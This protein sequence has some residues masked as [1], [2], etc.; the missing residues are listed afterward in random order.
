MKT[1]ITL[2]SFLISIFAINFTAHA[3][4][5]TAILDGGAWSSAGTWDT[6]S[7]PSCG[8]T[9][10]IPVGIDVKVTTNVVLD[11]PLDPTCGLVRINVAGA[12]RFSAGKKI[13]LAA[14]ACVNVEMGGQIS[15]SSKGGGASEAIE[16]D[17]VK[18]WQASD[19][20]Y[21]GPGTM[22]CG[23]V[24]P[25]VML[26]FNALIQNDQVSISWAVASETDLAYYQVSKSEDGIHWEA[27]SKITPSGSLHGSDISYT[28]YD[29]FDPSIAISYYKLSSFDMN[30]QE[31]R[32]G[33]RSVT[34]DEMDEE[35]NIQIFPNPV[36]GAQANIRFDLENERTVSVVI[37]NQMGQEIQKFDLDV[38]KDGSTFVFE[39]SDVHAGTYF[40]NIVGTSKSV[41]SKLVVL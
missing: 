29:V 36:S 37:Y 27:I 1:A 15:P 35:T 14:G 13:R 34:K 25:V 19:G 41:K 5:V 20:V 30:G 39:T 16:I 7:V 18:W 33:T 2:V 21:D 4:R 28:V 12:L 8:D 32:L 10:E 40:V 26:D 6:G 31:V 9:I 3:N 24:L 23:V 17:H 22:G 11:D 38:E